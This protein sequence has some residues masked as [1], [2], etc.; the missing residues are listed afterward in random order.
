MPNVAL[1]IPVTF[2][3]I[4][5]AARL[6]QVVGLFTAPGPTRTSESRGEEEDTCD[7]LCCNT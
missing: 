3:L 6:G 5:G 2:P 4:G 1:C 7:V